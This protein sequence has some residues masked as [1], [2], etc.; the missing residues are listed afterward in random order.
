MKYLFFIALYKRLEITRKVFNNLKKLQKNR[1]FNVFCVCSNSDEADLAFEFG[2]DWMIEENFPLGRKFNRGLY[3]AMKLDF[4]HLIQLGSDDIITEDLLE[5]YDNVD[6]DY[7]GIRSSHIM[8][9]GKVKTWTLYED[10]DILSPIGAGRVFK[11]EVLKKVLKERRL[12]RDDQQKGLDGH[13]DT[14]M[15]LSGFRCHLVPF[16]GVG[17][18]ALKS[19]VN[20]WKFEDIKEAKEVEYSVIEKY[21]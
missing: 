4:T 3:E 18:I 16:K 15:M 10:N 6:A 19:D 9:D 14:Q 20:I 7:F 8:K 11:K 5:V 2:F 1:D 12:W 21:L 17:T 13:S